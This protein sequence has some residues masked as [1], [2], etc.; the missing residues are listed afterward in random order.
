MIPFS[1][2]EMIDYSLDQIHTNSLIYL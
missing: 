2:T 1:F